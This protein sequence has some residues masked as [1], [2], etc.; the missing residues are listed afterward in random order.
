M[1]VQILI[2]ICI[3]F[4]CF[5]QQ[6]VQAQGLSLGPAK[7][8]GV[9]IANTQLNLPSPDQK[10]YFYKTPQTTENFFPSLLG[11][12]SPGGQM[13]RTKYFSIYFGSEETTARHIAD[14]CDEIL[15]NLMKH[16]P[17][18]VDRIAPIHVVVNDQADFYGNAFAVYS[19]NYIHFWTNPLDWELRGTSDWVRNTFVHE[20]THIVTMKAAHKG[21]PFQIA[22]LNTSRSNEN[23]DFSFTLGLYHIAVSAAFSEGVAQFEAEKYGDE[24]WDSHRDMILRMATLEDD[25]LS[26]AEMGPL[27]GKHQFHGEQV[28]N[29]GYAI[30]R[31]IDKRFGGETVPQIFENKPIVN[32]NSSLKK[33]TGISAKQLYRDWKADLED[34]YGATA[35]SISNAT[36]REGQLVLDMGSL[37]FHPTYS[38]DGEKIAF[39]SNEKSDYFITKLKVMDL[40]TK[41][42]RDI[43]EGI[44]TRFSWSASGDSLIYTKAVGGR[45]D[46]FAYTL[47]TKKESRLTVGLRGKDPAISPD[48]KRIAYV[49]MDDGNSNLGIVNIDG[50]N[51]QM[52]T[53]NNDATQY[54]GPKWSADG[55]QL[56][57]SIFRTAEDRD[58]AT[59]STETTP[60][61]KKEGRREIG[62]KKEIRDTSLDSLQLALQ[63]SI[64]S[65]E[66]SIKAFP[67]SLAFANNSQFRV[68]VHSRADERDPIWLSDGSGIVFSSDRTGIFNIY[69]HDIATGVQKQITNVVGSAFVPTLSPNGNDIIYAGYHA[70]NYNLYRIPLSDGVAIDAPEYLDRDYASIYD[71]DPLKELYDIGRYSTRMIS[72]GITPIVLLGPTFIGNRFGLDQISAGAQMSWGNLLGNDNF[73]ANALIGKN[74]KRQQDFNSDFA[75]YYENGL[76]PLLTEERTYAPRLF[77]GGSRSTINSIVDL[78]TVFAQQDTQRGTL[79]TVVDGQQVLIP[80]ATQVIQL[81]VTEEDDFKDVFS[82]ATIGLEMSLGR[83]QTLGASYGY[84]SYSENLK[85]K[86]VVLDSTRIFQTDS[87]GQLEDITSQV[88]GIGGTNVFLDDFL[89]KDLNFFKSHEWVLGWSYFTLTPRTDIFIN[90]SGGRAFSMRYRRINAT[91]TDSLAFSTDLNQDNIP[92]ATDLDLSPS[93]FREDQ[94]QTSFN[95]YIASYNEFVPLFGRATFSLQGFVA[96]KDGEVKEVQQDGGTF[97]GVFYYPLRYYLGGIGTLRGYPYF[98]ASGGKLAFFRANFT[99]PL[100][101]SIGAELPPFFFDKIYASFFFEAGGVSNAN[102]LNDIDFSWSN[103]KDT[104]L[105]DWGVELRFQMFSHYRIPAYGYFIMAMPTK[106]DV[107]IRNAPPGTFERVDGR[108]IY[109][110]LSI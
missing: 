93:L 1:K 49:G 46:V 29:Q 77:F 67:D 25:L 21:L 48:G 33:A 61:P 92:D 73:Y 101:Q 10:N 86:Q 27:G 69:T 5:N 50:T 99:I 106:R 42:T 90:P 87:A 105:A 45:W 57:F 108:R 56:L 109:F 20:L 15:E 65:V 96:Y 85:V 24:R 34:H 4:L 83:G 74:F 104:F 40:T 41:K 37:D 100:F 16:Y 97:E 44:D 51:R 60:E 52:L 2:L 35:D 91:I 82:D 17:T 68:I 71:G 14:I 3:S 43:A 26:L 54:Y 8:I 47:K 36:E 75:F 84:R 12:Y 22:V 63:D 89:Y 39:I 95:E 102:K 19:A 28:Y 66:D 107:Q 72:Y 55:K 58:I 30:L 59:I 11:L 6:S 110:G 53:H 88:P 78:G 103:A 7:G 98:T 31:Y 18:F 76:P 9:D 23:P 64:K 79:V 70:S 81:S 94:V 62:K 80:N 32:F 13:I 38:P